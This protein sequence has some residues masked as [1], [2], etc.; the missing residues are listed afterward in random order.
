MAKANHSAQVVAA[1]LVL[2]VERARFEQLAFDNE[3]EPEQR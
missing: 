2:N 1:E 3:V